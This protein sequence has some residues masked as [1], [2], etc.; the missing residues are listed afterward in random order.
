[1]LPSGGGRDNEYVIIINTICDIDAIELQ[2]YEIK[3]LAI[4]HTHFARA[5]NGG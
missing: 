2:V 1:M 5:H 3:F 4:I